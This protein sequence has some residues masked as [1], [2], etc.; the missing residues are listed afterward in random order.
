[1]RPTLFAYRPEVPSTRAQSIQLVNTAWAW[2]GRGH[3]TTLLVDPPGTGAVPTEEA[4]SYYGLGPMPGLALHPLA[5]GGTLASVQQRWRWSRWMAAQGGRGLV[6]ARNKR[7]AAELLERYPGRFTLVW[8]IHE[9]DSQQASAEERERLRALEARVLAGA[10]AVVANA[11]GTLELLRETHPVSVPSIVLHNATQ[12]G[13]VRHPEG[14][15]EGVGYVGSVRAYKGLATLADAAR[16][17]SLPITLV[18]ADP[19]AEATRELVARS[20]GR[21][22]IEPPLPPARVPDRLARFSVL[23]LPLSPGLF[24]ERLTSPL[25]LWDYLV[26]GRPVVAA[27]LPSVTRAAPGALSTYPPED[28]AALARALERA[29]NDCELR[30]RLLA[31]A[32]LRTWEQRAEELEAFLGEVLG[33][34]L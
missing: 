32:P 18:G 26:S 34:A 9:V 31:A 17:T 24:G 4:L 7:Y 23:V 15:G 29:H 27:D 11:P 20:G 30:R 19:E 3:P 1:M 28:P 16:L 12:P 10:A 22:R 14:A 13:R 8:E 33:E 6:I 5:R 25:K 21:L 2:A